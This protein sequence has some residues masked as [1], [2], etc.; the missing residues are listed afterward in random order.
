MKTP[1]CDQRDC[2]KKTWSTTFEKWEAELSDISAIQAVLGMQ[3]VMWVEELVLQR[4]EL[5]HRVEEFRCVGEA[6]KEVEKLCI[7]N[8]LEEFELETNELK[9]C[10]VEL[11]EMYVECKKFY[12]AK[13]C[14]PDDKYSVG[15]M[16][17]KI[18]N[19]RLE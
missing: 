12:D 11:N 13:C 14:V 2:M 19:C 18:S 17:E 10:H 1:Q 8:T 3:P 9:L 6:C 4:R 16:T 7:K 15:Q 5:A